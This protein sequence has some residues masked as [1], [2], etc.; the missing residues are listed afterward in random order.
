MAQQNLQQRYNMHIFSKV[1][2]FLFLDVAQFAR[3]SLGPLKCPFHGL[4]KLPKA[5]A[6]ASATDFVTAM[7]AIQNLCH[8]WIKKAFNTLLVKSTFH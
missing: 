5:W 2:I 3:M 7:V 4:S 6:F 1:S 8:N